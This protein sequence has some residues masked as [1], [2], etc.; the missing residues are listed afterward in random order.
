MLLFVGVLLLAMLLWFLLGHALLRVFAP[1]AAGGAAVVSILVGQAFTVTLY[2]VVASHGRTAML[3]LFGLLVVGMIL[4]RV[5]GVRAPAGPP[6]WREWGELTLVAAVLTVSMSWPML[7]DGALLYPPVQPDNDHYVRLTSFLRTTGAEC[8]LIDRLA[9]TRCDR[10]P[11]HYYDAWCA[12]LLGSFHVP[13]AVAYSGITSGVLLACLY[14][15]YRR[16]AEHFDAGRYARLVAVASVFCCLGMWLR[17]VPI[18]L[19]AS[20]GSMISSLLL[21]NKVLP[22]GLALA[23]AAYAWFSPARFLV[24]LL[25]AASAIVHATF[26]P[27]AGITIVL[28]MAHDLWQH[29]R[30]RARAGVLAL[31]LLTLLGVWFFLERSVQQASYIN[32]S[33]EPP[34]Y[35]GSKVYF[36]TAAK[37]LVRSLLQSGIL[38]VPYVVLASVFLEPEQRRA[39]IGGRSARLALGLMCAGLLASALLLAVLHHNLDSSQVFTNV[40][41]VTWPLVGVVLLAQL[42]SSRTRR[43]PLVRWGLFAAVVLTVSWTTWFTRNNRQQEVQRWPSAGF[44]A[45]SE[46]MLEGKGRIGV[47][48]VDGSTLDSFW[49]KHLMLG[50]AKYLVSVRPDLFEVAVPVGEIPFSTDPKLRYQEEAILYRNQ[51]FRFARQTSG[52]PRNEESM[53][54]A[55]LVELKPDHLICEGEPTQRY[56]DPDL[57]RSDAPPLTC[58]AGT[59]LSCVQEGTRKVCLFQP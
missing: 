58:R 15:I 9:E 16:L 38:L 25:L 52:P 55:Y 34:E 5:H 31:G 21:A 33:I 29:K 11:Y 14:G 35:F 44:L 30:P 22:A 47:R 49:K 48:L 17:L 13:V 27:F 19:V 42:V 36:Q 23:L 4:W 37:E 51:F 10:G 26:A 2:A 53:I 39:W 8:A 18:G 3:S 50:W 46:R 45:D 54:A 32:A 56:C 24:P 41:M 43:A 57:C 59:V 12:A 40:M 7:V 6:D 1:G 28:L 20:A